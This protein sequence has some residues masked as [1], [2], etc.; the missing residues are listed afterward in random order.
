V[1]RVAP[2][3]A[4]FY[5]CLGTPMGVSGA[6]VRGHE[7][8]AN[9]RGTARLL[10]TSSTDSS[11]P[12]AAGLGSLDDSCFDS[13]GQS[14]HPMP[15]AWPLLP[16]RQVHEIDSRAIILIAARPSTHHSEG[17]V[18][19][20]LRIPHQ[21]CRRLVDGTEGMPARPQAGRCDSVCPQCL[22]NSPRV[23][24]REARSLRF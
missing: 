1:Q 11:V 4:P 14:A 5:T 23:T 13:A 10:I 22:I 20:A 18:P 19:C 6:C 7:Q 15:N 17:S 8:L 3:R 9:G 24:R 2:V 16:A 21:D 12:S